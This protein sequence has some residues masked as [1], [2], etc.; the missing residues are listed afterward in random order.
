MK[1]RTAALGAALLLACAAYA[2][3][4]SAAPSGS[5]PPATAAPAT[6]LKAAHLFDGR[7]GTLVSPGLVVVQ[8]TR[9][10]AVGPYAS[11]PAGAKVID[12]GDATLVPGYIDAH[13]HITADHDDDWAQ[14]FYDG[15]LRFP[16]EQSFHAARN[17]K[18]TL[19]AGVTTV[20]DVGSSDFID[21]ALRNAINGNLTEGPRM[22]VAGH[23]TLQRGHGDAAR[24]GLALGLDHWQALARLDVRAELHAQ[25]VHARLHGG[26]VGLHLADMP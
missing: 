21:V 3:T 23:A 8:G 26:D 4:P 9:I 6:V 25:L 11:I 19:Q 17:A 20:R 16:V 7:S 24:A 15:M 13:T 14:G 10:L 12:L 22:L 2:Q 18:L 5:T 1:I